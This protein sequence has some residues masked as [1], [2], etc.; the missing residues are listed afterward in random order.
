MPTVRSVL[1]SS[2]SGI[3]LILPGTWPADTF[4]IW[5]PFGRI[6]QRL[7]QSAIGLDR[8]C[9]ASLRARFSR[10]H[11]TMRE[12]PRAE[13]LSSRPFFTWFGQ[14]SLRLFDSTRRPRQ[15]WLHCGRRGTYPDSLGVVMPD[16]RVVAFDRELW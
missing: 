6:K 9:R 12:R 11:A 3:V 2:T 13:A 4:R 16:G 1:S 5:M 10:T 14:F 7:A 8:P 15:S